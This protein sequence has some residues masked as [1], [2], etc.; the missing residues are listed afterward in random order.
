M[1]LGLAAPA[2]AQQVQIGHGSVVQTVTT[3][4]AGQFVWA[5]QVAPDGP[6]QLIVN[7]STQRALLFRNGVPIGAT[8]VSTGKTGHDTPTG[9]FTVLQKQ[10]E[11]HSSKYDNAPM[12]YMQR[13]T[14]GGV[15]LH[16]GNLPGFPA[17]HGCIRLP[18]A[19][20]KLLYRATGLGMTVVITKEKVTP[21][22]AP[23]P[24][25]VAASGPEAVASSGK[26]DW[27]PEKS[28]MGPVSVVL[29]TADRKVVVLRNGVEIGASDVA[30]DGPVYGTWAYTLRN[31]DALGQH[32]MRVSL[33]SDATS[34]QAVPPEE[35]QRFHAPD[36]FRSAIAQIVGPG[37]TVVVTS[38]LVDCWRCCFARNGDG[39][40]E[41][42]KLKPGK[43]ILKPPSF[44]TCDRAWRCD[45]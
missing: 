39:L 23:A 5:P 14:W 17:S 6:M 16:A 12:P 10:V 8:T 31:I 4:K 19:F 21:R 40:R 30:V 27:H 20:A 2:F 1:L 36:G 28:P 29:S 13:L 24:E 43:R 9:V 22:I 11:H 15:A 44:S 3:L 26:Y 35:W 34:H 38:G 42:E 41:G 18:A 33:S 7:L 32:W 45:R 25:I 37:T